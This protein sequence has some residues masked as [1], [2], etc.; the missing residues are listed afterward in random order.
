MLHPMEILNGPFGLVSLTFEP[1][2]EFLAGRPGSTG[3][4]PGSP[5]PTHKGPKRPLCLH[6]SP[7]IPPKG[8]KFPHVS[9][10]LWDSD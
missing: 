9:V 5:G 8:R 10:F 2:C 7:G 1:S 3:A 4:L 6:S